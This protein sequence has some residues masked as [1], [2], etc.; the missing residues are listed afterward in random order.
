MEIRNDKTYQRNNP[1]IQR[2]IFSNLKM[3]TMV[4]PRILK[5][6]RQKYLGRDHWIKL[7]KKY[8]IEAKTKHLA[9]LFQERENFDEFGT[10]D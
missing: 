9:C 2:I 7:L 4:E 6:N 10:F 3:H 5:K 1:R 8:R